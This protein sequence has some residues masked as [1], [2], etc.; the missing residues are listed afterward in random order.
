MTHPV[1][2]IGAGPV[3]LAAAAQAAERG[4]DFVVLEAGDDAG[5]AIGEWAHVRLFSSW[6]ELVD[7]AARRLLDATG[8]WTAP[9]DEAYPTG[10]DW[11]SAYLQPLAD[12]LAR[13]PGGSVRYRSRVVGV[14]R[15]GRD[16]VVDSGREGDPFTVH[17]EG[18]TGRERILGSAVVDASG[19]WTR[20][21]PLGADGYPAQGERDHADRITYGIPDL[22]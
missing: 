19:T 12:L 10:G 2:I 5:A 8:T 6:S 14:A 15:A 13:T 22:A 20:P 3:G 9:D 16:L 17:V 18:P 11:R 4:L 21:N 1:I 7:P